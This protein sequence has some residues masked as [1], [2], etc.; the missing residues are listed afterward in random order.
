MNHEILKRVIY[1]QH[2][3]IREAVIV[4]RDI[5]LEKDAN[6]VLVGIRRAGK[7]TLLY[8]RV[9]D[10]IEEG[11]EWDQIVYVNFDDER[12]AGFAVE[13]FDDIVL[14]AEEM[15]AKKHYF[16]FDEIQNITHWEK[17]AIRLANQGHK[18][19]ITGSNA[20]MLSLEIAAALG[21]RYIAKEVLPYSFPEYLRAHGASP[22]CY[23]TKGLARVNS[24]LEQYFYFGGFPASLG[25]SNKREYVESVYQKILFGDIVTHYHI[26]NSNGMRLLVAKLAESVMQS[27]SYTK[28]QNLITG[29]GYKL[30]K[31]IVIDYCLYCK[32]ACLT[33]TLSNYFASFQDKNSNPKFYFLDNGILHLFADERDGALL[34]NLVALALYRAHKDSLYYLKG[35]RTDVDFYLA[36]SHRAIQVCYSLNAQSR[37]RE[38]QNLV[39]LAKNADEPPSLTIVTREEDGVIESD[40]FTIQVVSLKNFLLQEN[41][42]N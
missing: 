2:R 6:Y 4:Q 35:D 18:V 21:G 10:L 42:S 13:D 27:L 36:D 9:Q 7:T 24:L 8:Q 26:R 33:F 14:V 30:S 20:T 25:F 15:S 28:L 23:D 11:V 16:Y 37:E 31:D 34:E 5:P 39:A 32:E 19:D 38:V 12:L 40:G 3:V 22:R 29:I 17:F 41:G 1:E